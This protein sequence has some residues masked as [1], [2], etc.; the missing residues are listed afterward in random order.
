MDNITFCIPFYANKSQHYENLKVCIERIRIFYPKNKILICKTSDTEQPVI[1]DEHVEIF[2]T[3]IDG[4]HIFGAM[5]LL[6]RK[7]K[8]DK[9]LICHDSMF[10]I[11]PLP[12][13][14]L[15]KEYYSL[16]HFENYREDHDLGGLL[17][18]MIFSNVEKEEIN[19][20]YNNNFSEKW[21]GIM[22]SACGGS[23][24]FLKKLWEKININ[25]ETIKPF[26]GRNGI[27]MSERILG[28]IISYIGG[29]TV[30]SINDSIFMQPDAF[31]Y[32]HIPDFNNIN[33]KGS[34]FFKIWQGRG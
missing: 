29:D 25:E 6:L 21:C 4:S 5:E 8:N 34:S 30:S 28:L 2:N 15:E 17:A 22:G 23:M 16:W 9:F 31:S 20:L 7:N 11:A 24:I 14:V 18:N 10:M 32:F 26:T 1:T 33:Y 27:M 13:S 3:F 19:S 12:E